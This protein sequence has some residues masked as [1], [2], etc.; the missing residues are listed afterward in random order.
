MDMRS[1]KYP[2]RLDV[3]RRLPN[4]SL[5]TDGY[6]ARHPVEFRHW[7]HARGY[8]LWGEQIDCTDWGKLAYQLLW[9]IMTKYG[10]LICKIKT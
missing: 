8:V 2:Y 7:G 1:A 5:T 9:E 10:F 4:G 6:A 3:E